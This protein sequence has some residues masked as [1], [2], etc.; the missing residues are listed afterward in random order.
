MKSS[1]NSDDS[2]SMPALKIMFIS[3]SPRTNTVSVVPASARPIRPFRART[4]QGGD[5]PGEPD[6]GGQVAEQRHAQPLPG[7]LAQL[8]QVLVVEPVEAL[9]EEV[10][11]AEGAQPLGGVLARQ[12]HVEVAAALGLGGAVVEP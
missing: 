6:R 8:D 12:Q 2:Y 3:R 9:A 1:M 5:D 11:E 4:E 7:H 10:A